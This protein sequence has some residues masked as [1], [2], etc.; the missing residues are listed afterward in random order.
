MNAIL[1]S[2]PSSVLSRLQQLGLTEA[3]L[4]RAVMAGYIAKSN[5]TENHPRCSR[6]S[7][8]GAKQFVRCVTC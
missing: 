3:A 4:L 1:H 5:C 6:P 8:R 2:E 7:R